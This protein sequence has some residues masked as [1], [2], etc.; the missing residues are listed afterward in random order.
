MGG[1]MNEEGG[2][3]DVMQERLA[4]L[5][6]I[7][8]HAT[9]VRAAPATLQRVAAFAPEP[10]PLAALSAGLRSMEGRMAASTGL[11][12]AVGSALVDADSA[13][14][15]HGGSGSVKAMLLLAAERRSLAGDYSAEQVTRALGADAAKQPGQQRGFQQ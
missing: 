4:A 15:T 8:G 6:G 11:L 2:S 14:L 12:A 7:A 5:A 9:L 1:M 3:R 13:V 10:A